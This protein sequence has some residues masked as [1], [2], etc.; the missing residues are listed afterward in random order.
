MGR[1]DNLKTGQ[2]AKLPGD[3]GPLSAEPGGLP[4]GFVKEHRFDAVRRWRFDYAWI[5]QRIALEV[6]GG[7]F[8]MGRHTRGVGYVKDMEKYSEAA[9]QG[10]LVLRVTPQQFD[11]GHAAA[12]VARALLAKRKGLN[13]A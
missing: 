1:W 4:P 12:L 9:L 13:D 6:E 11:C 5:K 3:Y 8:A 2:S 10:W 7:A